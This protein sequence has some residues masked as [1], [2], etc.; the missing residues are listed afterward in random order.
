MKFILLA[1]AAIAQQVPR[2][3]GARTYGREDRQEP[4]QDQ[5]RP[6]YGGRFGGHTDVNRRDER[7]G[8]NDQVGKYGGSSRHYEGNGQFSGRRDPWR[9]NP[10]G[11]GTGYNPYINHGQKTTNG[12]INRLGDLCKNIDT[13]TIA[14]RECANYT[15]RQGCQATCAKY[16]TPTTGGNTGRF[17][18]N[19]GRFGGN[20]GTT[21]THRTFHWPQRKTGTKTGT[22]QQH[23]GIHLPTQGGDFGQR[24]HRTTGTQTGSR[25]GKYG[26]QTRGQG[27]N[28]FFGNRLGQEGHNRPTTH[29]QY[30]LPTRSHQT[31]EQPTEERRP[32]Y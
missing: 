23:H 18:G 28:G 13:P 7:Y 32:V 17:G 5:Q 29:N 19:T 22:T 11:S 20:T 4:T 6:N 1:A 15:G 27:K 24:T 31:Q 25:F 9:A 26:S 2:E 16:D 8:R 3:Q 21:G 12:V 30:E 10:T 14:K